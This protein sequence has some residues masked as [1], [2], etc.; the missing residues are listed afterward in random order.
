MEPENS[1]DS[2]GS[3]DR[4]FNKKD[5]RN[6]AEEPENKKKESQSLRKHDNAFIRIFAKTGYTA[7]IIVMAV[8]LIMAFIVSLFL[9]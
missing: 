8:G 7:W 1:Q 5:V 2:K 3:Q 4:S 9:V 6:P